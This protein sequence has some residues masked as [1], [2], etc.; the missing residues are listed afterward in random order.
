MDKRHLFESMMKQT[1]PNVDLARDDDGRNYKDSG[2]QIA[3]VGFR[4]L[5]FSV[6][7]TTDNT[8]VNHEDGG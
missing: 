5:S 3:W 2:T 7:H 4:A 1:V 6:E 8:E